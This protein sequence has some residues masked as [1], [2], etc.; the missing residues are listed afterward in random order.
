PRA[1]ALLLEEAQRTLD[2]RVSQRV[3]AA[4]DLDERML[5]L[6]KLRELRVGELPVSE[7]EPPVELDERRARQEAARADRRIAPARRAHGDPQAA[8]R[9]AHGRRAQQRARRAPA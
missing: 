7:G 3:P 4:G 8:R 1:G 5:R 6:R 2:L 9:A